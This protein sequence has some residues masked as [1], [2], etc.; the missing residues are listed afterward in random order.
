MTI[1]V[2]NLKK[3]LIRYK[4]LNLPLINSLHLKNNNSLKISTIDKVHPL[5]PVSLQPT[6]PFFQHRKQSEVQKHSV[7]AGYNCHFNDLIKLKYILSGRHWTC[8][9]G[10]NKIATK[11]IIRQ[12]MRYCM[13]NYEIPSNVLT[14]LLNSLRFRGAI[15]IHNYAADLPRR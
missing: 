14:K 11:F 5:H 8:F 3:F 2:V 10:G 12:Y 15:F 13:I 7:P 1:I 9:A 4:W 6:L